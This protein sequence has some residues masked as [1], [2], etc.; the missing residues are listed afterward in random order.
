M[1]CRRLASR[2][3]ES[4]DET[5]WLISTIAQHDVYHAGEVNHIRSI[6]ASND[7]WR[8]G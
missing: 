4:S 3:G 8:W 5:R 1:T 2:T 6:L 7:G